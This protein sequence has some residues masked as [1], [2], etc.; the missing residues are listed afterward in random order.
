MSFKSFALFAAALC[1]APQSSA[2]VEH[3]QDSLETV[4]RNVAADKA[5]M[6]DVRERIEWKNGHVADAVLVPMSQLEKRTL[7][8]D[9]LGKLPK[10]RILYTYCIV[11]MRARKAA[12]VLEKQGYQVRPLKPGFDELR[13]A[14]FPTADG[15]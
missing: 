7:P 9:T 4:K 14:G 12:D 3:T 10:D 5:I 15:D 6:V 1:V 2:A 8:A 13:K 11:G